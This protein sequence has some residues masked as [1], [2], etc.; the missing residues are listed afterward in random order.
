[1]LICVCTAQYTSI[2]MSSGGRQGCAHLLCIFGVLK[3]GGHDVLHFPYFCQGGCQLIIQADRA[4]HPDA[5]IAQPE[6]S[7]P[8]PCN[9]IGSFSIKNEGAV[10]LL[11]QFIAVQQSLDLDLLL[12]WPSGV[13]RH[14]ISVF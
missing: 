3:V 8:A 11:S 13:G 10:L 12:K 2:S 9:A 5:A 4:V 6:H 7:H 1:M 14:A